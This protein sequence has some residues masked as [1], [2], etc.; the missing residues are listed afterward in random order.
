MLYSSERLDRP[1]RQQGYHTDADRTVLSH[2]RIISSCAL[3]ICTKY[4]SSA[5]ASRWIGRQQ[6]CGSSQLMYSTRIQ[7]APKAPCNPLTTKA[8]EPFQRGCPA[9]FSHTLRCL[10]PESQAIVHLTFPSALPRSLYRSTNTDAVEIFDLV[11]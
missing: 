4:T 10:L 3:V 5:K 9:R 6:H 1:A 8:A 11:I 7:Y 2:R